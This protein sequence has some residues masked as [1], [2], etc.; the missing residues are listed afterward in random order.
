LLVTLLDPALMQ[1]GVFS[2]LGLLLFALIGFW[3]TE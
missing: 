1:E 3:T 2:L